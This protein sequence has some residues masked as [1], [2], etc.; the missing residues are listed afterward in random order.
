MISSRALDKPVDVMTVR[1]LR[2]D[3]QSRLHGALGLCELVLAG[4]VPVVQV[5]AHQI[6]GA[7]P[8]SL[9]QRRGLDVGG[10]WWCPRLRAGLPGQTTGPRAF[11]LPA[12]APPPAA[13]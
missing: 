7:E 10:R 6:V 4:I 13:Q 2:A 3:L 1:Q 12:D 11:F 9:S 5:V 8:P